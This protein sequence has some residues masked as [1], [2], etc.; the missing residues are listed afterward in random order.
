[1]RH[2]GIACIATTACCLLV[3]VPSADATPPTAQLRTAAAATPLVASRLIASRPGPTVV[4][5]ARA[6]ESNRAVSAAQADQRHVRQSSSNSDSE[7][8]A[9]IDS[10]VLVSTSPAVAHHRKRTDAEMP[11]L[12]QQV[13]HAAY[14]HLPRRRIRQ[15]DTRLAPV[16]VTGPNDTVPGVGI[17]GA[18]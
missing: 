15:F 13:R 6:V 1:M 17:Q 4:Q 3:A 9:A 16:I 2:F 11:W 7:R 5:H 8:V 12:W 10:A 18:F 14:E